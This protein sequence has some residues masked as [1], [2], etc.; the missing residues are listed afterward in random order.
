VETMLPL[1][2]SAVHDGLLTLEDV[3]ERL[4][5]RPAALFS[6]PP[7]PDTWVEIDPDETWVITPGELHSRA[8]WTPFA[9]REVRGRV[10]RVVLRSKVAY[11][12]EVRAAP[13][14]GRDLRREYQ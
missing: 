3:I 12:G 9:G 1:L 10:T 13:G 6:L 11:D 2:L 5:T 8:G 4:H 14:T 7:Q